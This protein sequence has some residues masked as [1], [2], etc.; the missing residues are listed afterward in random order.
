MTPSGRTSERG[1]GGGE[2]APLPSEDAGS[3]GRGGRSRRS[4]APSRADTVLVQVFPPFRGHVSPAALR[5]FAR[6]AIAIDRDR[7]PD[8][9]PRL[10][11]VGIVVADDETVRD[12]NGRYLGLDE[13][14]DVLAF[15]PVHAGHY[16]GDEEPPPVPNVPFPQADDAPEEI[17][18]VVIAYPY[19]A[20]QAEERGHAASEEVALLVVHGILHLLGHD[21]AEPDEE[22]LMEEL[23]RAALSLATGGKSASLAGDAGAARA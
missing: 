16:E 17:G 23:Q 9:D 14:T 13:A 8:H 11:T 19:A 22:R 2:A 15:S 6:A 4:P 12:L 7:A 10:R 18:E 20:R 5:R 21:H 1:L 3:Q